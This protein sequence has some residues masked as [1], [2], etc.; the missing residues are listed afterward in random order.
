MLI[1]WCSGHSFSSFFFANKVGSPL[2]LLGLTKLD[3]R[4][5]PL[6]PALPQAPN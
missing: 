5:A 4:V 2:Q 1:R 3:Q 6:V